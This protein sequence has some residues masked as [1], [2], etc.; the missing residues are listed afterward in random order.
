MGVGKTICSYTC[1]ICKRFPF[2]GKWKGGGGRERL[3]KIKS[4]FMQTHIYKISK[5]FP[6][7]AV[8]N[9]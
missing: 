3:G 6:S 9:V 8:P 5:R 1:I 7:S 2:S 4:N